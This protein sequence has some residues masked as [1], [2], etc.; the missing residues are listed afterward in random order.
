MTTLDY[1]RSPLRSAFEHGLDPGG[2]RGWQT[3]RDRD[4]AQQIPD[5]IRQ[6][7]ETS[8]PVTGQKSKHY[9]LSSFQTP[10]TRGWVY[11]F[12]VYYPDDVIHM[13]S[14]PQEE[15]P[16]QAPPA[17]IHRPVQNLQ[18]Y[19]QECTTERVFNLGK[20]GISDWEHRKTRNI[21][22]P[23]TTRG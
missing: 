10:I 15:R 5:R 23:T 20:V 12:V 18:E 7:P 17:F 4:S 22:V 6:N 2:N 9:Y 19:V 13:N 1:P 8:A 11:L 16:L 14:V 3:A 21:F